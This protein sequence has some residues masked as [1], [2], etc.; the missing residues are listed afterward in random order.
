[1]PVF[2]GVF[3]LAQEGETC[4]CIPEDA[5]D[6]IPACSMKS[7]VSPKDRRHGIQRFIRLHTC[8]LL[9]HGRF[10]LMTSGMTPGVKSYIVIHAHMPDIKGHKIQ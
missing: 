6:N 9:C 3:F 1:V 5:Q 8:R 2:S 4:K 10:G 7:R